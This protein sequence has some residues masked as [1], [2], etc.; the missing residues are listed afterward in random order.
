MKTLKL[1]AI[2]FFCGVI[3]GCNNF[4]D[5]TNDGKYPLAVS[6]DCGKTYLVV[7][8]GGVMPE[9]RDDISP[10]ACDRKEFELLRGAGTYSGTFVIDNGQSVYYHYDVQDY[11][12][13]FNFAQNLVLSSN[14]INEQKNC[15][16][17]IEHMIGVYRT[18][19][20]CFLEPLLKKVIQRNINESP[21]LNNYLIGK[22]V[23][24]EIMYLQESRNVTVTEV[25]I[26]KNYQN[27]K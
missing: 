4:L 25:N 27:L 2:I 17:K 6:Q 19:E 21:N 8:P 13:L 7:L 3:A 14:R 1:A 18:M 24:G 20:E 12:E 23:V 5:E 22:V 9:D 26:A 16:N 15:H 10:A 11:V